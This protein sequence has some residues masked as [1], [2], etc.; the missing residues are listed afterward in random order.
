MLSKKDIQYSRSIQKKF[1]KSYFLASLFFPKAKKEATFVLYAF[2]R[3]PDEIV[4]NPVVKS[5]PK[6]LL[7]D[8]RN[9]W[10][11]AI[12]NK[13]SENPVLRAAVQVHEHFGIPYT[14]SHIFLDAMLMDTQ[15][16]RYKTFD[17]LTRY[18]DGSAA[19]VGEMMSYVIGFSSTDAL[20]YARDLGYAM[21]LTNFLRDIKEDIDDRNRIYIPLESLKTY[22]VKE[23]DVQ[24]HRFT[25]NMQELMQFEAS[26]ARQFYRNAE[27]GIP[28]LNRDGQFAVRA[29]LALYEAILD[30]LE[31]EQWNPY[32]KRV[33]T[34]FL[35]KLLILLRVWK[36]H[37]Q[38]L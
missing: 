20:Q 18:M 6:V 31:K 12:E 7:Q 11:K 35:K 32:K 28:L 3:E 26:R 16:A 17:E 15:I 13:T 1:G 22:G 21:Q 2:F 5:D 4:D 9:E 29:A 8:W 38:S 27:K 34:S 36:N 33:K 24:K 37:Q 25:K 30:E 14:F 19:A 10:Q 23:E